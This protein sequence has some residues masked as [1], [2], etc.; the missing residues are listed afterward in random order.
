MKAC[1][2]VTFFVWTLGR[3]KTGWTKMHL[4]FVLLSAVQPYLS[5]RNRIVWHNKYTIFS[6]WNIFLLP[7]R[8]SPIEARPSRYRGFTITLRHTTLGRTPL[9]EWSP[10]LRD[11][12]LTTHNTHKRQSSMPP[13]G[14]EST[15]PTSERPQTHALDSVATGIGRL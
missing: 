14:F 5:A 9:D 4:T 11:L 7:W 8:N 15:I 12:Y 1:T 13:A 10:R 6:E 2:A 3:F